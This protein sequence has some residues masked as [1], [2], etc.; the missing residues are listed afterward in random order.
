[1]A[2][3]LIWSTEALADLDAIAKYIH[4][5]SPYHAQRAVDAAMA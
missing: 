3:G 1:M 5:D 2:A 4:R